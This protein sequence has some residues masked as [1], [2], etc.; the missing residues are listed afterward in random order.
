[1]ASGALETFIDETM[2]RSAEKGYHATTFIGMRT[3]HGTVSAISRLVASG[4][5]QSGFTKLKKLGLLNYTIE[6]AVMKFPD[7]FSKSDRECAAFRLS[8]V[9]GGQRNA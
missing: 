8:L 2:K 5:I 3:R 6:A 9:E 7:E 4:D 1:M